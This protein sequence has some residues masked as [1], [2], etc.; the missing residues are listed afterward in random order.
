MK[1]GF[2]SLTGMVGAALLAV[3]TAF[4]AAAAPPLPAADEVSPGIGIVPVNANG[5]GESACSV[6]FL[7]H[8]RTGNPG[9]LTAGHC[10]HGGTASYKN[11]AGTYES[12]GAFSESI[13]V[14]NGADDSDI[15]LVEFTAAAPTDSAIYGFRPV[16]GVASPVRLAVGDQLCKFGVATGRQCGSVTYVSPTK[17]YFDAKTDGGDSGGPVYYRN[18]DGT[19]TAVGVTIRTNDSGSVAEAELVEPWLA[20]WNLTLDKTPVA[21]V[22]LP[23]A[24]RPNR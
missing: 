6:G 20:K 15:A 23:A 10:D 7:V 19:A 9:F 14:D 2:K 17:V 12:I 8:T 13:D 5:G 22:P 18:A 1:R 24:Y 3:F 21:P 11:S 16:T 4:P